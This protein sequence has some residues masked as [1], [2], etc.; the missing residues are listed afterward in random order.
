MPI[1]P[2]RSLQVKVI[3][4][5]APER[6]G[7]IQNSVSAER[8]RIFRIYAEFI[9]LYIDIHLPAAYNSWE[10]LCFKGLKGIIVF[11]PKAPY[12]PELTLFSTFMQ[13]Q[14]DTG[15]AYADKSMTSRC[16]EIHER[17]AHGTA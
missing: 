5:F 10:S 2:N 8:T 11:L 15:Q 4:V 17:E 16:I 3:V 12:L 7:G 9:G 6:A 1:L 13:V 14:V